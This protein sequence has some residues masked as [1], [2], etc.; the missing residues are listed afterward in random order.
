MNEAVFTK[1]LDG[2]GKA[3]VPPERKGETGKPR[4]NVDGGLSDANN[5][6]NTDTYSDEELVKMADEEGEPMDQLNQQIP[7]EALPG[8]DDLASEL[9][10]L[11]EDKEKKIILRIMADQILD[12]AGISR[13]QWSIIKP[14]GEEAQYLVYYKPNE[15]APPLEGGM[16][17]LAATLSSEG[18]GKKG[19]I[20]SW[21][22]NMVTLHVRQPGFK[23]G[24]GDPRGDDYERLEYGEGEID[25]RDHSIRVDGKYIEPAG[26]GR[27]IDVA[28]WVLKKHG[29]TD[30][31]ASILDFNG[32]IIATKGMQKKFSNA[33]SHS[34]DDEF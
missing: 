29:I 24:R 30:R 17:R 10:A 28:N 32:K 31:Y 22:R 18:I 33:G 19:K 9:A 25:Y 23:V 8:D 6:G 1:D 3:E 12:E 27:F 20:R 5:D 11:E 15:K 21:E 2:D 14:F 13:D 16:V 34:W 26:D 4:V 7:D